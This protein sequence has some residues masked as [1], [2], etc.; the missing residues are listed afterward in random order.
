MQ[1]PPRTPSL[2]AGNQSFQ[3]QLQLQLKLIS[4]KQKADQNIRAAPG[5]TV[6]LPC[7][8]A[9][10]ESVKA[11][12]WSREDMKE[13]N[14]LINRNNKIDPVNQHRSYNERVDLQMKDGNVSLILKNVAP[15]DNGTYECRLQR[16]SFDVQPICIISLVVLPAGNKDGLKNAGIKKCALPASLLVPIVGVVTWL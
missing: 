2:R 15:D 4:F 9:D 12:E 10:Y 3:L 1:T 13:E 5:D 8:A 7:K 16:E 6:V 14:V 11:V